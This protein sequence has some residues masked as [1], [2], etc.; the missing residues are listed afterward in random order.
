MDWVAATPLSVGAVVGGVGAARLAVLPGAAKWIYRLI[1]L[2][3]LGEV[4][5][6]G[7]A[8]LRF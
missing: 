8:G 4:V 6:L 5:Q 7:L 3:V 2:V 1:V